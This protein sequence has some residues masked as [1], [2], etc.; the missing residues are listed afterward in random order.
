[1]LQ[2]FIEVFLIEEI[3]GLADIRDNVEDQD[4]EDVRDVDRRVPQ[5]AALD[6]A[7][8]D[9]G[10]DQGQEKEHIDYHYLAI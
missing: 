4:R 8:E 1:M 7:D 5:D 6:D 3:E 10:G 9:Q 2:I